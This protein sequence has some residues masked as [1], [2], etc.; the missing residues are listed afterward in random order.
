MAT[1][2]LSR[3][4]VLLYHRVADDA[5]AADDAFAVTES[6]FCRHADLISAA[7][8]T[9]LF[10]GELA[11]CL[12]AEAPWPDA[13]MAITFD[14]G[15]QDTVYAIEQLVA[16]QLRCSVFVTTGSGV[17][18]SGAT[19]ADIQRLAQLPDAV[20]LGAHSRT[21]PRLDELSPARLTEEIGGSKADLEACIGRPVTTFAYPHG[22]YDQSARQTVSG[23][24]FDAAV[25]VK[26]A[27]SHAQ[28]DPLA[29]ARLTVHA[30]TTDQ[31]LADWLGGHGA[32]AAWR[33]ERVRT[34][35][36]RAYRRA[37]RAVR[38]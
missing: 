32:P 23:C 19:D 16:R 34:R 12:R 1:L 3:V 38:T 10:I 4:P 31:Q 25:G 15:Y 9:P 18:A 2:S 28:D 20:E 11:R 21:H 35:A 13:P 6:T 24:G 27:F 5:S 30:S 33:R 7:G 37:R 8:R 29:I 17:I 26:N 14:D 36:Y 22:A